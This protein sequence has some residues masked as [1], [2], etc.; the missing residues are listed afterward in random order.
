MNIPAS[1]SVS[2]LFTGLSLDEISAVIDCMG[3]TLRS[4]QKGE[5]VLSPG[6]A[7]TSIGT[8]VAGR[9][10]VFKEDADANRSLL[11]HLVPGDHFAEV[12]AFS[13]VPSSPVAV[14][15]EEESTVLFLPKNRF[16]PTC[17]KNCDFHGKLIQNL[18]H[19]LSTKALY[20]QS[21]MAF[22]SEKTLRKKILSYLHYLSKGSSSSFI[23][24]FNREDLADYLCVDRSALSR[25]LSNLKKEG[26]IDYHKNQFTLL[27]IK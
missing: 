20:L 13:G 4:Y 23:I 16:L 11:A 5:E 21:R 6:D 26:L 10:M 25:E 17:Q 8:L 19:I 24:P 14:T 12:F 18:L 7:V 27:H 2:S 22:L 1:L 15:A 3:G 9:L